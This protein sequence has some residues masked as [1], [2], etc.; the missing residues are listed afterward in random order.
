M[1]GGGAE[2]PL[3]AF[4]IQFAGDMNHL[5]ATLE[6]APQMLPEGGIDVAR[7]AAAPEDQQGLAFRVKLKMRNPLRSIRASIGCPLAGSR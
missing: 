1:V 4:P 2:L 3:R 6:Q 5:D 7:A